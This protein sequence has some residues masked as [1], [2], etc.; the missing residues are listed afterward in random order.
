[1]LDRDSIPPGAKKSYSDGNAGEDAA[2]GVGLAADNT[3]PGEATP[4][5]RQDAAASIMEQLDNEAIVKIMLSL[6]D[7]E[8]AAILE[9]IAKKGDAEARRA[10]EIIERIRLSSRATPTTK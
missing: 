2:T 8:S 10:A 5:H 7:E 1:M 3:A 6:K 4:Y 9:A